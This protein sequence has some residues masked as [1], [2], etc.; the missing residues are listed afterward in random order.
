MINDRNISRYFE[1]IHT[2]WAKINGWETDGM[3]IFR[4]IS[5]IIKKVWIVSE[6][7]YVLKKEN[8]EMINELL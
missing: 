2:Y 8:W 6:H 1:F 5:V 7:K 3:R 4:S